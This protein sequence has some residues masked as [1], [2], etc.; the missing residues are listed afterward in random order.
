M[1][2]RFIATHKMESCG[3]WWKATSTCLP[4]SCSCHFKKHNLTFWEKLDALVAPDNVPKQSVSGKKVRNASV[5]TVCYITISREEE[6][7]V[8]KRAS[9]STCVVL[10]AL[11]IWFIIKRAELV[12]QGHICLDS[13]SDLWMKIATSLSLSLSHS[14]SSIISILNRGTP[15]A[16]LH[17]FRMW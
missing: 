7:H 2:A 8:N 5:K 13:P 12:L 4:D 9:F 6:Q 17:L 16:L 11:S 15:A 3:R 14:S 10:Q 1:C